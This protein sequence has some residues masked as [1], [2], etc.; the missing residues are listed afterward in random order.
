MLR[1]KEWINE[2][3]MKIIHG[4]QSTPALHLYLINHCS[5]LK[6]N[7]KSLNAS[8]WVLNK[9]RTFVLILSSINVEDG[10]S[11]YADVENEVYTSLHLCLLRGL[12]IKL[13]FNINPEYISSSFSLIQIN[14][15]DFHDL[16][17]WVLYLKLCMEIS[18]QVQLSYMLDIN[19]L[20]SRH[21]QDIQT[22]RIKFYEILLL[23]SSFGINHSEIS[24][25][26]ES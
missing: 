22:F 11:E 5:M 1:S 4:T 14:L 8:R 24:T 13:M 12:L 20:Q 21:R 26:Y 18:V 6:V 15:N 25:I 17:Y 7:K 16:L 19:V 3:C 9:R 23:Q 2:W 10:R